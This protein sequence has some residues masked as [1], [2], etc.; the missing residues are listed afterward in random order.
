MPTGKPGWMP[1]L[2]HRNKDFFQEEHDIEQV[3]RIIVR[4]CRERIPNYG[5]FDPV[6]DIQVITP[7]RRTPAGVERLN[8]LAA[9]LILRAASAG[10][11]RQGFVFR[12]G[13]KVMQIRNNYQKEVLMVI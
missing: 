5:P 6:K 3:S 2:N 1:Q 10:A 11:A 13:D 9:V 7:M 4:L 8:R 12:Q